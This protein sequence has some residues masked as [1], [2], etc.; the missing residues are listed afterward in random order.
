MFS[1]G[2]NIVTGLKFVLLGSNIVTGSHF[3]LL[4][5]NI[6]TVLIT[7]TGTDYLLPSLP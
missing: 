7:V 5:S 6:A 2:S 4:G 1:L 3:A